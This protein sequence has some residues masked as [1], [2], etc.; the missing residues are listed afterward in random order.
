MSAIA[1]KIKIIVEMRRK[2]LSDQK[3]DD[4]SNN[5]FVT[6]I[7]PLQSNKPPLY[8]VFAKYTK[9]RSVAILIRMY[10][11]GVGTGGGG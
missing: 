5:T 7:M 8:D 3:R 4:C 10:D 2:I 6:S 1:L 11:K 9:N